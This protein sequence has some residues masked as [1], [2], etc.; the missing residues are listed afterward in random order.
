MNGDPSLDQQRVATLCEAKSAMQVSTNESHDAQPFD[1]SNDKESF[2]RKTKR[3]RRVITLHFLFRYK[4]IRL[5]LQVL[6]KKAQ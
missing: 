2:S 3:K 4:Q 6:G 1:F 5:Q